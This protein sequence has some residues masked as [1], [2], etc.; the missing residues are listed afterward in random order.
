MMV[1]STL[2]SVG[3]EYQEGDPCRN[4]NRNSLGRCTR[5]F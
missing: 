3:G 5:W 4:F 2:V 1:G